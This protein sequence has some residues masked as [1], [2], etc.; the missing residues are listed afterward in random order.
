LLLSAI[1]GSKD[2]AIFFPDFYLDIEVENV[3]EDAHYTV[4][5][6]GGTVRLKNRRN[7]ASGLS[8]R[9]S[10]GNGKQQTDVL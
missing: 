1:L 2:V 5:L 9:W 6:Y 7:Q 3:V 10:N 8:R 4:S